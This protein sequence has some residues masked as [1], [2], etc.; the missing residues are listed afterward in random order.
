[1]SFRLRLTL[2]KV[3]Q[4]TTNGIDSTLTGERRN[5]PLFRIDVEPGAKNGLKMRSQV[6]V[7]KAATVPREKV[8]QAFGQLDDATLVA[9]ESG[10]GRVSGVC[11]KAFGQ[12]RMHALAAQRI[13][14][15]RPN[16]H[17]PHLA[18]WLKTLNIGSLDT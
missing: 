9:V 1:T 16:F 18:R 15:R 10:A 13:H 2:F 3:K 12:W 8:G 14:K 11:V 6:M 17:E 4:T 7:D 5:A